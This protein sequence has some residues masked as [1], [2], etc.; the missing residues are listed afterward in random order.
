MASVAGR[1]AGFTLIELLVVI[2]II[3]VLVALLVPA[4]QKV[5]EAAA[6]TQCT[7]NLKQIALAFHSHH[8]ALKQF[9][10]AGSDGPDINCCKASTRVGWTWMYFIL[11]YIDQNNIYNDPNDT[12]VAQNAIAVYYCP[13][14]RRPTVYSNGGR[15]DY[16]GNGGWNMAD[17]GREGVLV[18]QW[19]NPGSGQT[20]NAPIDQ[21]RKMLDITDGTS[22]TILVGEKQLHPAVAGSAGGDNEPWNNSGW[23]QDHVR[24]GEAVPEPDDLHP[25]SGATFWSVRFG[26]P[27]PNSFNAALADGSVRPIRYGLSADNWRRLCLIRDGEVIT[28]EY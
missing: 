28:E 12:A 24:F 3:A 5:R 17:E 20:I 18:R 23:D 21:R 19:K 7:N 8:D 2:A 6:R 13:S 26:G 25:S 15:G 22:N 27:H 1:R 14:R 4:V 11:P 10:N 16:G 9:P